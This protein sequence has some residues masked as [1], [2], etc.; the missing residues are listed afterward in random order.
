MLA[1]ILHITELPR[2]P[3]FALT[4]VL[5]KQLVT[6]CMYSAIFFLFFFSLANSLQKS[7]CCT[8]MYVFGFFKCLA[9]WESFLA[10]Q[11]VDLHVEEDSEDRP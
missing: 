9:T 8:H 1:N 11:S 3:Y 2:K 5:Q 6:M 7:V 4:T 10:S